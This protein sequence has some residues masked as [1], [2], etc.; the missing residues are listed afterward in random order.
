MAR[1]KARSEA[2]CRETARLQNHATP[3]RF[4]A[5]YEPYFSTLSGTNITSSTVEY[6][7]ANGNGNIY[8]TGN[9]TNVSITG[10]TI[11]NSST[12]GVYVGTSA[13]FSSGDEA[14][15]SF[16]GNASGDV[17]RQ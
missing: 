9:G 6:G 3:L 10:N 4:V 13:T 7:G 12:Y 5:H 11:R 16:S 8:T 14:T 2:E 15:N 17:Y 1:S